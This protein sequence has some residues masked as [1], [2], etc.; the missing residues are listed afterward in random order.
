M[1]HKDALEAILNEALLRER[2]V[3]NM[4]TAG[5]YR[6]DEHLFEVIINT[7]NIIIRKRESLSASR[8]DT[9]KLI[10]SWNKSK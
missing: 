5:A 7:A 9:R 4:E 10:R 2:G 8:P 3:S 6:G 1:A